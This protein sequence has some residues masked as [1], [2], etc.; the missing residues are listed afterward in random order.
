MESKDMFLFGAEFQSFKNIFDNNIDHLKEQLDKEE[1]HEYDSK[2]CLASKLALQKK[3]FQEY[4]HYTPQ[5]LKETILS[6]LNSIKKM[7][8]ER[9]CREEELRITEKDVKDKQEKLKMEKQETMIQKSECSSP[10]DNSDAKREKQEMKETCS[11]TFQELKKVVFVLNPRVLFTNE[12]K[13]AFETQAG[14]VYMVKD[15][16]DD[17]LV[18]KARRGTESE[19]KDECSKS[20]N[21]T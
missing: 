2:T 7:I 18:V 5:S 1:L 12:N 3:I 11:K 10:G 4:A 17:G 13:F 8:D 19:M 15:K 16:C 14:M 9:A 6:Y 20:G 21:D